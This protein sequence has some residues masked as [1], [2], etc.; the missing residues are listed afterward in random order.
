M[1][2]IVLLVG[3][4]ASG[5]DYLAKSLVSRGFNSLVSSTT[6]P[7]RKLEQN[8]IEYN[9][10]E[11][12][13]EFIESMN[14]DEVLEH[15][16]YKTEFGLWYYG[17]MKQSIP[18]IGKFNNACVVNPFG[19]KQ[20]LES[21]IRDRIVVVDVLSPNHM[22]L[23]K[24]CERYGGIEN[25]S[26]KEMCEAFR[27]EVEDAKPFYEYFNAESDETDWIAL[28]G[29]IPFIAWNHEYDGHI[30]TIYEQIISMLGESDAE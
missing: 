5:K 30:D 19:V 26:D 14:N 3:E 1:R 15:A 2:D 17:L 16:T 6:R 24:I 13:K 29:A 8:G 12:N 27:R 25:M 28:F 7:M 23:E 9:F 4:S 22:R 20:L 11:S 18:P 10:I 21:S